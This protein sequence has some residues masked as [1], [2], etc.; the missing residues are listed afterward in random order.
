MYASLNQRNQRK[1]ADNIQ[2]QDSEGTGRRCGRGAPEDGDADV[3][4]H[5]EHLVELEG[6]G[7][8]AEDRMA[9]RGA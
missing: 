9:Q 8:R 6:G 5:L 7:K 3:G 1:V 2:T 4:V